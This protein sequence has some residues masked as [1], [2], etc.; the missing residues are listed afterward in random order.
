M[1]AETAALLRGEGPLTIHI[2]DQQGEETFYKVKPKHKLKKVF[3][4]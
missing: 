2:C 1:D 4:E 3:N